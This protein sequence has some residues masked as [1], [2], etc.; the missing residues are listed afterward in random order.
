MAAKA[1]GQTRG[2][3]VTARVNDYEVMFIVHP[4]ADQD[5]VT[6]ISEQFAKWVSDQ[7]GE[8]TKSSVLGRRKLAFAIRRQTE[9]T[10]VVVDVRLTGNSL[11]EVERSLKL[12]EQILRY[13]IIRLSD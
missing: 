13:L 9:G 11:A 10:Y 5:G 3:E 12:H 2:K 7:G 1:R 4:E 8:V 6:A